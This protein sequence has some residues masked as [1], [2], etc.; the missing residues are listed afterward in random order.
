MEALFLPKA[1]ISNLSDNSGIILPKQWKV[2]F[3][4]WAAAFMI[5]QTRESW[6]HN[7]AEREML[8]CHV[9]LRSSTWHETAI[10]TDGPLNNNNN[11]S[12]ER[13][14]ADYCL[15]RDDGEEWHEENRGSLNPG[16][17]FSHMTTSW[18][19]LINEQRPVAWMQDHWESH[20]CSDWQPWNKCGR[21]NTNV[22]VLKQQI[23]I[24]KK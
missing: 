9:Q 11:N 24:K 3:Q 10:S 4:T 5:M 21:F 16:G 14:S 6:S 20:N 1:M 15:R 8:L 18:F 17:H 12:S 2:E 7:A 23:Y 13:V 19:K 22:V